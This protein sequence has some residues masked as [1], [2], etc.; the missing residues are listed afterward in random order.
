MEISQQDYELLQR[1][2][3]AT[4]NRKIATKKAW[5]KQME[6]KTKAEISAEMGRRKRE[7]M[8]K[9]GL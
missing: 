5:L 2:K 4:I 6:G 1:T 3:Q 8:K 9:A 7:G